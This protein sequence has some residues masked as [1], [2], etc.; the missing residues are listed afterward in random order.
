MVI[1]REWVD[2]PDRLEWEHAGYKCLILRT[3]GAGHLCG[4]VGLPKEHPF[5]QVGYHDDGLDDIDVHGGLTFAGDRDADESLW[6]LGFD[7][8]H[9]WDLSPGLMEYRIPY[10]GEAYRNMKYV[11]AETESLARQL[12]N[13]E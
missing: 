11:K 3:P 9:A 7:C 4:Y 8:G 12:K 5:Y 10:L 2:E 6:W 13:K 1:I